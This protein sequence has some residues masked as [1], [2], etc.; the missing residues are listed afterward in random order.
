MTFVCEWV[1]LATLLGQQTEIGSI[2]YKKPHDCMIAQRNLAVDA[3][4]YGICV[5]KRSVS[6][7]RWPKADQCAHQRGTG[8]ER[9]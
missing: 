2:I 6:V 5:P 9:K 3:K 7:G 4:I 8:L 1:L